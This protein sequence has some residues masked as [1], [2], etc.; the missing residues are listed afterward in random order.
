VIPYI[1]DVITKTKA[2]M[3]SVGYEWRGVHLY[4][5]DT[6]EDT[7]ILTLVN[8]F[9]NFGIPLLGYGNVKAL[10]DEGLT[11]PKII[12]GKP[13]LFESILGVNGLKI[14]DSLQPLKEGADLATLFAASGL[15]NNIGYKRFVKIVDMY[16]DI[17]DMK[18]IETFSGIGNSIVEEFN[19]NLPAFKKFVKSLKIPTFIYREEDDTEIL[20]DTLE[21][22][23]VLFTG[24]RDE[25]L[26]NKVIQASGTMLDSFSK[27]V[28]ILV[29]KDE[30]VSNTKTDK[31]ESLGIT[32]LTV[33][34]LTKKLRS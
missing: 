22:E 10:Y 32:I 19:K 15:F 6:H 9:T 23:F 5:T 28:T 31:A 21:N 2:L 16:P 33:K 17:L 8:F 27:K 18:G 29:I 13:K 4:A 3:P 7:E 14:Y 1:T 20:N 26:R 11:L 30:T 24:F 12:H 25:E 34:Q